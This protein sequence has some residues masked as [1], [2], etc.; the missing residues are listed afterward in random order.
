[1]KKNIVVSGVF[2]LIP[3]RSA[4]ASKSAKDR[5]SQP[6]RRSRG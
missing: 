4:T 1:M 2:G 6:K 3:S 5:L